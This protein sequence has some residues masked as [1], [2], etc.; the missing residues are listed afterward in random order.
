MNIPVAVGIA[1][2]LVLW[3]LG[4]RMICVPG[5]FS[6]LGHFIFAPFIAIMVGVGVSGCINLYGVGKSGS[7]FEYLL[8][9]AQLLF[10]ALGIGAGV[11]ITQSHDCLYIPQCP[12]QIYKGRC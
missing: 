3:L 4:S 2:L 9:T 5:D 10:G 1:V 6:P 11:V 12:G 7:I 8:I